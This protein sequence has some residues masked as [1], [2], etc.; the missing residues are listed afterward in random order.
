MSNEKSAKNQSEFAL[1]DMVKRKILDMYNISKSEDITDGV[2]EQN[3]KHK[4]S[5]S[6]D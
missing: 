5:D 4:I 2:S 3:I 6:K 1:N